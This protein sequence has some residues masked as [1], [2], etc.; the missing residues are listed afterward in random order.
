[1]EIRANAPYGTKTLEEVRKLT[2]EH[3]RRLLFDEGAKGLVVACNTATSA[4][5]KIL[6]SRYPEYFYCCTCGCVAC[7]DQSFRTFVKKQASCMLTQ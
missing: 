7:H 4:A 5:V 3:A 6:R 2:C 1:M